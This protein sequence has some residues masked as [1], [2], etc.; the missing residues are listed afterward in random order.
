MTIR[1]EVRFTLN[2]EPVTAEV[3]PVLPA[4][5]LLRRLRCFFADL[6]DRK[7]VLRC[8][9]KGRDMDHA[10]KGTTDSKDRRDDLMFVHEP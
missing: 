4:A 7:L 1:T 3:R 2:G 6:V 5:E 10:D 9:G 8:T